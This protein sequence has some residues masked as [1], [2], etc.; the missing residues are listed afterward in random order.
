MENGKTPHT[1]QNR[2]LAALDGQ[3]Y[4]PIFDTIVFFDWY[5]TLSTS[6]FW[7]H[8]T[9]APGHALRRIL[10]RRLEK[11]FSLEKETISLWM[12]GELADAE[13]VASLAVPLPRR[14]KKDYLYRA[15]HRG[16]EASAV[17]PGMANLVR[18]LRIRT[19]TA[20]A[21]DNMACFLAASP[22]ALRE[23]APVDAILSSSERGVLKADDPPRFFAPAL[24]A[25]G[26]GFSD[27]VLI[28]DCARTCGAF[29]SFGGRAYHFESLPK[30]LEALRDDAS[31]A[32]RAAARH[33][34]ST[35]ADI[36]PQLALFGSEAAPGMSTSRA[37]P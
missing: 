29:R 3:T 26:M 10:D 30:L 19:F 21:T 8:I 23:E 2:R 15:L 34:S 5:G 17:D 16:C 32:V 4:L 24:Q 7:D 14:Y 36:S 20:V 12:R 18:E 31:P 37:Y 6:R 33:A 1:A 9:E 13:V 11:L 22:A 27:A 25:A 35:T 28:D